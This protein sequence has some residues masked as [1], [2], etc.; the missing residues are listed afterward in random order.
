MNTIAQPWTQG[1][2]SEDD[3]A[4]ER[5]VR[6][7]APEVRGDD[8]IR[9][10]AERQ[11]IPNVSDA[12]FE[13]LVRDEFENV[14][15]AAPPEMP[16]F[17]L[18]WLTTTSQYDSL[19]RRQRI[20]YVPVQRS[21]LPRFDPSNGVAL[22]NYEGVITC[23]EM[24]LHKIEDRRYQMIMNLYHHKRPLESEEVILEKIKSAGGE[25]DSNGRSLV[26]DEIGDGITTLERSVKAASRLPQ[27]FL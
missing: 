4:D 18:C 19:Q 26:K 15:L 1:S 6:S 22:A 14:S 2:R 23:N 25:A 20:G 3:D 27:S 5:L 10:D 9:Q 13:A 16:G 17:H 24:V 11:D 21:E 7:G 8:S 12:E